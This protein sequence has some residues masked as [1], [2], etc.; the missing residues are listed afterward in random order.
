VCIIDVSKDLIVM[1]ILEIND[2]VQKLLKQLQ[3]TAQM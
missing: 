2:T 1:N 3:S